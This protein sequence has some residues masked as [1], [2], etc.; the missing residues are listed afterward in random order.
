MKFAYLSCTVTLPNAANRRADGFEH[1]QMMAALT[2]AFSAEGASLIDIAWDDPSANWADFDAVMIGTTWDYW[3]RQAEFLAQ[4]DVIETHTRLF[5]PAALVRWN[6]RKTYLKDL[7]ARGARTVPTLWIDRVTPE[8]AAAAFDHF[9][10]D[11]LVFKRQVGAGAD[12]QYRI[13]RGAAL[14]SMA[15]RMMVQPFISTIKTEGEISFIFIDAEVSHALIKRAATDDY[16]IQALY[17]GVEEKIDPSE[18]DKADASAVFGMLGE[19]PLYARVDMVR[20]ADGQLMVMEIELIEP[21]LYP[22]Q[23][24]DLGPRLARAM[25]NGASRNT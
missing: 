21:F 1:D 10:T 24:P 6:S 13:R 25:V 14:P 15:H 19:V 20:A 11:D 3:D 18:A 4:L 23:G 22:L 16:R 9:E 12:G 5:N 7:Q 17:G 8:N 2:P